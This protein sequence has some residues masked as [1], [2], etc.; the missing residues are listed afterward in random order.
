MSWKTEWDD[1]IDDNVD[2][3]IKCRLTVSKGDI[4][5]PNVYAIAASAGV[6]GE[7][8]DPRRKVRKIT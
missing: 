6:I 4:A 2:E 8:F 5:T 1:E 3:I 7:V